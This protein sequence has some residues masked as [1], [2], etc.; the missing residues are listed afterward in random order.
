[1]TLPSIHISTAKVAPAGSPFAS[2][3]HSYV[4]NTTET[5][6]T[7]P[8][9]SFHDIVHLAKEADAS[10]D[11]I[12]ASNFIELM[13]DPIFVDYFNAFM[14][15]P[16]FAF[17]VRFDI[18]TQ[19]FSQLSYKSWLTLGVTF[20]WSSFVQSQRFPFFLTSRDL[21]E[22][23]LCREVIVDNARF[24]SIC[25]S[26]KELLGS[27]EGMKSLYKSLIGTPGL[28]CWNF[29]LFVEYF[30]NCV[31]PIECGDMLKRVHQLFLDEN[32]CFP[33]PP[34]IRQDILLPRDGF[35]PEAG[36]FNAAQASALDTLK[37]YWIPRYLSSST[38][39]RPLEED[40]YESFNQSV[41]KSVAA[42][43][44]TKVDQDDQQIQLGTG[45]LPTIAISQSFSGRPNSAFATPIYTESI[46]DSSFF[47]RFEEVARVHAKAKN[48]AYMHAIA[49]DV[50]KGRPFKS[51]L[52][53]MQRQSA[54]RDLE[55]IDAVIHFK[56]ELY[57]LMSPRILIRRARALFDRFI[58]TSSP[59]AISL[60]HTMRA[61]LA[62]ATTAPSKTIFDEALKHACNNILPVWIEYIDHDFQ[63]LNG[64]VI[65][66]LEAVSHQ[67][68]QQIKFDSSSVPP[69]T[70]KWLKG[71]PGGSMLL[72]D[73]FG[74]ILDSLQAIDCGDVFQWASIDEYM[75][76][77]CKDGPRPAEVVYMK[78]LLR[79]QQRHLAKLKQ[80]Q[81]EE[82]ERARLAARHDAGYD[83]EL[84]EVSGSS[85]GRNLLR[86]WRRI[87]I[88]IRN[89]AVRQR[90]KRKRAEAQRKYREYIAQQRQLYL[91]Q[92]N[93]MNKDFD[94]ML[95]SQFQ[96]CLQNSDDA[97][98]FRKYLY[99]LDAGLEKDLL[100]WMTTAKYRTMSHDNMRLV[101]NKI[102]QIIDVFLHSSVAPTVQ[103]HISDQIA[104]EVVSRARNALQSDDFDELL[105]D[106]AALAIYRS[107]LAS[108]E[109]FMNDCGGGKPKK[110][111]PSMQYQLT[112]I[113][114][115]PMSGEEYR[116]VKAAYTALSYSV[117]K[118]VSK[119]KRHSFEFRS[120]RKE[121]SKRVPPHGSL[122]T[123]NVTYHHD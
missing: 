13:Q 10:M 8:E 58:A 75:K 68:D 44:L 90:N 30:R 63:S 112:P 103:I 16:V 22:C 46:G 59:D 96:K 110:S 80:H 97:D 120:F 64:F 81:K 91:E 74:A 33:L 43:M 5:S 116:P 99:M 88:K 109:R 85:R 121:T 41:E 65:D 1:M 39:S 57:E 95:L 83:G 62:Q 79:M 72:H 60:S 114:E 56:T 106:S 76:S 69:S 100:F 18:E 3:T 113:F 6:P 70:L 101:H 122:T 93:E 123:N 26:Y 50:D 15:S 2:P 87:A 23:K 17:K 55:F 28:A 11:A 119:E 31:S 86:I 40:K 14:A 117:Q 53:C 27:V 47:E 94:P 78:T 12:T 36:I 118:G 105:F 32:A 38:A 21:S 20:P 29:W 4:S 9:S 24:A 7:S 115:K 54:V 108:F 73:R 37:T 104:S 92:L 34:S 77:R 71:K 84:D 42:L 102:T 82:I 67:I 61:K 19:T 35:V 25:P 98:I 66:D 51:Y 48:E 45:Q 49:L 111:R 52:E 107:L 89:A